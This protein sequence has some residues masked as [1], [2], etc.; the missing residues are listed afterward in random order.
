MGTKLSTTRLGSAIDPNQV[1][2]REAAQ[3]RTVYQTASISR[4]CNRDCSVILSAA[5]LTAHLL[6]YI[7]I[8]KD[9]N[10]PS[11]AQRRIVLLPV[12]IHDG[13]PPSTTL[14]ARCSATFISPSATSLIPPLHT[15]LTRRLNFSGSKI[16]YKQLAT[17]PLSLL[18]LM[19]IGCLHLHIPY[20][21]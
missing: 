21:V 3:Q 20:I 4:S 16:Y 5:E 8:A 2:I 14:T 19:V 10:S 6:P 1:Y 15:L 12:I 9:Q 11:K 18:L 13:A 7:S 17:A